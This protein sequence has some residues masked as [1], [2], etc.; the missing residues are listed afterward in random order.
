MFQ[1]SRGS[2]S[3]GR[4]GGLAVGL[5]LAFLSAGPPV[6]VSAQ[7]DSASIHL[8]GYIQPRFQVVGDSATFL[9]RRARIALDAQVTTWA[10][11]RVQVEMR[12]PGAPA[13]P[14]NSPLTISATDLQIR[15]TS[16]RWSGVVGQFR[17]PFSLESITSSGVLETTERALMVGAARRDIGVMA[18]WRVPDHVAVQ[19]AVV[20]GDGPNRTGNPDNR[21]AYLAR[22]M[23]RAAAGLDVGLAGAAYPDSTAVDLQGAYA[24]GRWRA[25]AEVMRERIRSTGDRK[26]GWYALAA[27]LVRPPAVQLVA[28]AEQ[29][30]PSD[31][32]ATDRVTGYSVGAQYFFA[33]DA[34]KLAADYEIF[35]EQAVQLDNNR[36]VVQLQVRF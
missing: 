15:L 28:R 11:F 7:G 16:P 21:M 23:V 32:L 10:A 12:T 17:V 13:T 30:D 20:N 27:Y 8:S 6:R 2:Q 31:T 14:P 5:A 22:A 4:T 29:L 34:A 18:E 24:R 3:D 33:G 1:G 36:A 19:A 26:T 9:L 35:R 25:R